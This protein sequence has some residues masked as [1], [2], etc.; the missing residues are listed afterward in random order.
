VT[1]AWQRMS[2][3][4]PCPAAYMCVCTQ[5]YCQISFRSHQ[6]PE[7]TSDTRLGS[8]LAMYVPAKGGIWRRGGGKRERGKESEKEKKTNSPRWKANSK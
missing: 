6:N 1:P 3:Q 8:A 7:L 5:T 4:A 2:G